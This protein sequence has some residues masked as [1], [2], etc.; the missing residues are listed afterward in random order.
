MLQGMLL[1][2]V[3]SSNLQHNTVISFVIK[4]DKTLFPPCPETSRNHFSL[5][6]FFELLF[7]RGG[8]NCVLVYYV[9]LD[10]H[11]EHEL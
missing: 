3:C 7:L 11:S 8:P 9:D 4:A 10:L 6:L 1:S 5:P 2:A